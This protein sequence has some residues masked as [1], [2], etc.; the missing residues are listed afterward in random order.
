MNENN[1]KGISEP[2]ITQRPELMIIIEKLRFIVSDYS[3]TLNITKDKLQLIKK[4]DE[5]PIKQNP[6]IE[7]ECAMD[8]INNLLETLIELNSKAFNNFKNL[9]EII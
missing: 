7:P 3:E 2:T 6:I 9:G 4:F 8:E 1:L 5:Y